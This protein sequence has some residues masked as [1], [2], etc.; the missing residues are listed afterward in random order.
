MVYY[1]VMVNIPMCYSN[2]T[3]VN[4][5][6]HYR[7]LVY[8]IIVNGGGYR[9]TYFVAGY[10]IYS[11]YIYILHTH[12]YREVISYSQGVVT[13]MHISLDLGRIRLDEV[14]VDEVYIWSH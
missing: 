10:W 7:K 14:Y 4:M 11:P 2:P 8:K 3:I 5:Y 9:I 12:L 13:P 6:W 1:N